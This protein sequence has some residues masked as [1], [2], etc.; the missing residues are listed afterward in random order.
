MH[1]YLG[2]WLREDSCCDRGAFHFPVASQIQL[3][4]MAQQPCPRAHG[5]VK[6]TQHLWPKT[7]E[8]ALSMDGDTNMLVP[9]AGPGAGLGLASQLSTDGA[10][11]PVA[12]SACGPAH[13]HTRADATCGCQGLV[14]AKQPPV[15]LTLRERARSQRS[16]PQTWQLG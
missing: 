16:F 15:P 13:C 12:H 10:S 3:G 14:S 6:K 1:E 5:K 4:R 9:Q 11:T 7:E 8:P 2:P